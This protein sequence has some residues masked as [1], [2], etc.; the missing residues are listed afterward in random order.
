M[1]LFRC[2]GFH[3]TSYRRS[4]LTVCHE[5]EK[6]RAYELCVREVEQGS[7]IHSTSTQ[8]L[9]RGGKSGYGGVQ[10]VE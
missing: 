6:R 10:T 9:R 5:R 8:H 3:S 4:E 7:C 2:E 1:C